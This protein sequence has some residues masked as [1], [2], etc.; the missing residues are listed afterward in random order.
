M[1]LTEHAADCEKLAAQLKAARSA[2]AAIGLAKSTSN[3]FRHRDGANKHKIDV[4]NFNRVLHIDPDRMRA[5]V[6]A[7]TTYETFVDETLRYGLLP[8]VVPQLKTITTGGAVSGIG[9]ESSSFRFGLVHETVEEMEILLADGRIITCS[10]NENAD[11]FFGFPNS[12]GTLGYALRLKIRLIPTKRY[13]HL[14]H[15]KFTDPEAYF[16]SISNVR[17]DYLDGT[18]FNPSEMYLTKGEFSDEAPSVSDYTYMRVYYKSIQRKTEDWLTTK[19]YIWRWDTD[20]FWCSKHFYVQNPVV[21]FAATPWAL[22]SRTYQRIMRLSHR[23]RPGSDG[24]ESVI[25]DVDIPIESAAEFFHFLHAE[26]GITPVWVC[27]IKS[28]D[29]NVTYD[30]YTLD[31]NKLY[32]NFGFWDTI[33]T[34]HEDGYFNKKVEEK[35]FD[36]KGK[37]GLYSSAWYDEETFWKIYNRERYAELKQ[38]YDPEGAFAGLY[39]KCVRGTDDRFSSTV[40]L[41]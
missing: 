7:M 15:T 5:D 24:T 39:A 21:R 38:K 4:R 3:L 18:I 41:T 31:P 26:I 27:P 20:W 10:R 34:T 37:K 11:L 1:L 35:A 23:L 33:P 2:G 9:I 6:E 14:T 13:V 28:C 22:N 32:I 17:A 16:A 29:P 40:T 30:L 19:G 25:Q 36:L 12:Y 8:T